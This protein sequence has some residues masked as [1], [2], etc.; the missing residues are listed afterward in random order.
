MFEFS[1]S[2]SLVVVHP[3]LDPGVI[4]RT[5]GL[6]PRMEAKAGSDRYDRRG[7]PLHRKAI[8]SCWNHQL[9]EDSVMDSAVHPLSDL[10]DNWLLKLSPHGGFFQQINSEGGEVQFKINWFSDSPYTTAVF[11]PKVLENC[12]K[13]GLGIE[14]NMIVPQKQA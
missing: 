14:L 10:I 1:Y 3:N 5:L 11:Q 7:N 12:G 2:A 13:I 6:Q 8:L 4:T 9:H